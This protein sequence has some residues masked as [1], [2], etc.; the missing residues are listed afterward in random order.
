[1]VHEEAAHDDPEA[2]EIGTWH[3]MKRAISMVNREIGTWH[4]MKRAISMVNR[5][6]G[7]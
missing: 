4:L 1:M 7:N 3:L 6:I 2:R 5:E